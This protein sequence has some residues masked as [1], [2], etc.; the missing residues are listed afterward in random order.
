MARKT[1]T[2]M[3]FVLGAVVGG[4]AAL[5][6]APEKGEVT[7]QRLRE[8]GD[9]ALGEGKDALAKAVAEAKDAFRREQGEG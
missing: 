3:A 4:V 9:K 8:A 7:R 2:L 6:L 5:L 1:D